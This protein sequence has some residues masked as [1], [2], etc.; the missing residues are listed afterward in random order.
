MKDTRRLEYLS[1]EEARRLIDAARNP[2]DRLFFWTLW[3]AGAR[4]SEVLSL[5]VA[6]L[7]LDHKRVSLPALKRKDRDAKLVALWDEALVQELKDYC[8]ARSAE[9]RLFPFTRQLAYY[10]VRVAGRRAGLGDGV[11]PHTLRHSL[12]VSWSL[13]G[14]NLQLLQRQ[15]GHKRFSTTVDLYQKFSSDDIL[16]EAQRINMGT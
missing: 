9:W 2:V 1:P 14:G 16:R 3:V 12:A 15:L 10:K 6:D 13:S 4:V 7:D 8:K 5:T 11:H